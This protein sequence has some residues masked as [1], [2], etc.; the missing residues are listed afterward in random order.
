MREARDA[1]ER[2]AM[3]IAGPTASG[4]L[5]LDKIRAD[6]SHTAKIGRRDLI[7]QFDPWLI[8]LLSR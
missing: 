4:R 8:R 6:R 2:C 1:A 7:G 5:A 3:T